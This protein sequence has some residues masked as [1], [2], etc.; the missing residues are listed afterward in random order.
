MRQFSHTCVGGI[1]ELEIRQIFH[2]VPI[3]FGRLVC[4]HFFVVFFFQ[5]HGKLFVRPLLFWRDSLPALANSLGYLG[6]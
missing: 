3:I 1:F 5:F 6:E 2:V 4:V